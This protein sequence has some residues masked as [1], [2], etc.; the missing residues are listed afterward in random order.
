VAEYLPSKCKAP[1]TTKK[2]KKNDVKREERRMGTICEEE[3][4]QQNWGGKFK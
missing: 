4:D 1:S 2:E 3:G